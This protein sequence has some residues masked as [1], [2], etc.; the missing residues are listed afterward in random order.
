VD[1]LP[2]R[3]GI[4][5]FFCWCETLVI[6]LFAPLFNYAKGSCNS[7]NYRILL[8]FYLIASEDGGSL[9]RVQTVVLFLYHLH[10]SII[11]ANMNLVEIESTI[12][13]FTIE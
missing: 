1:G 10:G 7:A 6:L 5:C 2:H 13:F 11:L 3:Q 8:R 12:K 4:C 9:A